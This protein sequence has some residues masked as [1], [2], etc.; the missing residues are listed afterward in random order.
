MSSTDEELSEEAR[1]GKDVG[2]WRLEG[3]SATL[4]AATGHSLP[5]NSDTPAGPPPKL[6]PQSHKVVMIDSFP[7]SPRNQLIGHL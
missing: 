6:L 2:R 1:N 3:T 4:Q 5:S 7:H